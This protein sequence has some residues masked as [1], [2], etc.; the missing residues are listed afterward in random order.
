M[1]VTT[2]QVVIRCMLIRYEWQLLAC[3]RVTNG[4]HWPVTKL[5]MVIIPCYKATNGHHWPVTKLRIVIIG[6]LQCYEW[7]LLAR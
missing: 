3:N 6:L 5:R 4:H 7:S 1:P 2:L